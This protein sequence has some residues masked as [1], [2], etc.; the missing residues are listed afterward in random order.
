MRRRRTSAYGGLDDLKE[1]TLVRAEASMQVRTAKAMPYNVNYARVN[2]SDARHSFTGSRYRPVTKSVTGSRYLHCANGPAHLTRV[3]LSE[4]VGME[5]P[6]N[7]LRMLRTATACATGRGPGGSV[8]LVVAMVPT[9]SV[10][11]MPMGPRAPQER[12]GV[13]TAHRCCCHATLTSVSNEELRALSVLLS[14]RDAPDAHT[15]QPA[16]NS[17]KKLRNMAKG[18]SQ[19]DGSCHGSAGPPGCTC[20]ISM[21]RCTRQ[22]ASMATSGGWAMMSS[23]QAQPPTGAMLA[24]EEETMSTSMGT[25]AAR[26]RTP[27]LC[28]PPRATPSKGTTC[29]TWS[30]SPAPLPRARATQPRRELKGATARLGRRVRPSRPPCGRRPRGKF[31]GTTWCLGPRT[32]TD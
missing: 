23:A 31:D 30:S 7:P 14:E 28:P 13:T 19:S 5:L 15:C 20:R 1:M 4:S 27:A 16:T 26:M 3:I 6:A 24:P 10:L 8:I 17:W 2:N 22:S 9:L 29:R 11:T 21:T 25:L 18:K 12:G 32:L